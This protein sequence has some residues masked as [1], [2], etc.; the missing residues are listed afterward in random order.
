MWRTASP[1]RRV[2]T[3]PAASGEG[4]RLSRIVRG[5]TERALTAAYGWLG[6]T[7]DDRVVK[8]LARY[9]ATECELVAV[10]YNARG[11]ARSSGRSSWTC[12]PEAADYQVRA[13][14]TRSDVR[15]SSITCLSTTLPRSSSL[16]YTYACVTRALAADDRATAPGRLRTC[17]QSDPLTTARRQC[18]WRPARTAH[19]A[20]HASATCSCHTL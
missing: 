12:R 18:A 2:Y 17:S 13:A 6:G 3:R 4:S 7:Q 11:V 10:T 15:H 20:T 14:H 5:A 8:Y 19:G 16:I 9:F 1:S